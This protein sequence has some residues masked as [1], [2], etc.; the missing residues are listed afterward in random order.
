MAEKR[1]ARPVCKVISHDVLVCINVS[2][3][4]ARTL[5]K[6][7]CARFRPDKA[8]GVG[9]HIFHQAAETPDRPLRH[10]F[11]TSTDLVC[12]PACRETLS[13]RQLTA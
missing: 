10:L 11:F 13:C 2:G 5:A 3:H 6:M 1:M 4:R 7:E 9:H 8:H 12:V